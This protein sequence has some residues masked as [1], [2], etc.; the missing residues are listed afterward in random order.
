[1][2]VSYLTGI[3]LLVSYCCFVK[4]R[5]LMWRNDSIS[6]QKMKKKLFKN[7]IVHEEMIYF[8]FSYKLVSIFC[9]FKCF[10]ILNIIL[11]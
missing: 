1:M 4:K 8:S 5:A 11:C 9:M 7:A 10:I 2:I 3:I 6:M